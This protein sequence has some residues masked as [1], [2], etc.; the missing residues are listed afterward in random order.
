MGLPC[1][2]GCFR[3]VESGA[4]APD[5]DSEVSRNHPIITHMS[6]KGR[7]SDYRIERGTE[8]PRTLPRQLA[9]G[10]DDVDDLMR[11]KEWGMARDLLHEL[12]Q[13][14]PKQ[15]EVL[16]RLVNVAFELKDTHA[17]AAACAQLIKLTPRDPDLNFG[18]IGGYIEA[19]RP[20]L[21]LQQAR[22]FVEHFPND[23]NVADASKLIATFDP[24]V[25]DIMSS[26]GLDKRA[27]FDFA[28]QHEQMQVLL[29]QN[30]YAQ[31][32]QAGEQLLR[33]RPNFMPTLNNLSLIYH[34]EGNFDKAIETARRTLAIDPNNYHALSNLCRYLCLSG[35]LKD[36]QQAATHLKA[37]SQKQNFHTVDFATKAAEALSYLGDDAGVLAVSA[38]AEADIEDASDESPFLLHLTAAATL[39]LGDEAQAKK[40]WAKAIRAQPGL[41]LAQENVDDLRKPEGERNAPF[42]YGLTYWLSAH[43]MTDVR[44][45]MQTAVQRD[46]DESLARAARRIVRKHPSLEALVPVLLDRGDA[47]AREMGLMLAIATRTPTLLEALRDFTL[48]KR[49]TDAQRMRA[50]QVAREAG[51]LGSKVT[52]WVKGQQQEL[53]LMGFRIHHE[54]SDYGHSEHVKDLAEDAIIAMREGDVDEAEAALKE[55]LGFEPEA[56]DLQMNL[57]RIYESRGDKERADEMLRDIHQRHPDYFFG[58]VGMARIHI[59]AGRLDEAKAL[60]N[61]MLEMTRIHAS[62]F[63]V[64]ATTE[65]ELHLAQNQPEG[66]Q[67]WLDMLKNVDPDNP[68]VVYLE[69]RLLGEKGLGKLAKRLFGRR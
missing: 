30:N 24:I 57:S 52:L 62:E 21:A 10:L 12:D 33:R 17:Y 15:A 68:A 8:P 56:P 22:H 43:I 4:R 51:L 55:A 66:A 65:G 45:E 23:P 47:A 67:H 19:G 11:A 40:L 25:E 28:C 59:D 18:L 35:K 60:L 54:P 36:A 48:S 20:A 5:P 53:V 14:Y 46:D 34:A 13:R 37:L 69:R 26:L 16:G 49:G 61:P 27:D 41:M 44:A 29:D 31:A 64:L 63:A 6:K 32:R 50:G 38:L 2:N 3:E 42:A 39:R 1:A 7:R 9:E 58:R